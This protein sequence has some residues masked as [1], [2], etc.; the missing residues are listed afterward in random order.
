MTLKKHFFKQ[1]QG[2]T[3]V[4]TV[5]GL[6]LMSMLATLIYLVLRPALRHVGTWRAGITLENKSHLIAQ[7]INQDVRYASE[8]FPIDQN[9][10][11]IMHLSERNEGIFRVDSI[12]Y[13]IKDHVLH[14]NNIPMH[15]QDLQATNF[16]LD[17]LPSDSMLTTEV[18]NGAHIH[19]VLSTPKD[20]TV[21]KMFIQPRKTTYWP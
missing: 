6:A 12:L 15:G 19:L 10:W 21:I 11:G 18:L 2:F 1:Q 20:S 9:A 7:R 13:V 8:I 16:R 4:E 14:R 17:L 3:F 5:I